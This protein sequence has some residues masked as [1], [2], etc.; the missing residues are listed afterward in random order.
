M[1][2]DNK[3]TLIRKP[4]RW[5]WPLNRGGVKEVLF[6]AILLTISGL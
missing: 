6:N 3:K 5:P 4:K 1:G 2:K